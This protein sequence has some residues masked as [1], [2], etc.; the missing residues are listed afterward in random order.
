M[1]FE[2]DENKNAS[3]ILKHGVDF[4]TASRVFGDPFH[5]TILSTSGNHGE[6]RELTAGTV[7]GVEILTVV[8]TDRNGVTRII[9]ARPASN[10]ERK[11]YHGP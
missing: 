9:S 3:N 2:W 10:K 1:E 4:D 6:V 7:G 11:T 8:H 5:V